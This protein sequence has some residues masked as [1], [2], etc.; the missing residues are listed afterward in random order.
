MNSKGF[1]KILILGNMNELGKHSEKFHL[2][3]LKF[4]EKYNFDSV[5]L[6][7]EFFEL[8]ISKIKKPFNKYIIK[9]N[10]NDLIE[11]IKFDLHKNAMLLAKCSNSSN[12]NKF[13]TK[14]INMKEGN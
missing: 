6:C 13:G 11:F 4:V 3:V 5:I 14:F 12:V 2:E 10:E 7:G 1:I 9:K 8:A